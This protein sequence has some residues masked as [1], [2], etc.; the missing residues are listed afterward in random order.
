MDFKFTEEHEMIKSAAR[1]F[2]KN[3]LLPGV[4]ERDEQQ[5]FPKEQIQKF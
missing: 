5:K 4:I 1:D 3:E 2:A